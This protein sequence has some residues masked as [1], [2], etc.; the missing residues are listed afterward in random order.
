MYAVVETGGKQYRVQVGEVVDV[1]RLDAGIGDRVELDRVLMV[2][3]DAGTQVGNPMIEGAKVSATVVEQGRG[4]CC[5]RSS[6]NVN[7]TKVL[8]L[9][10]F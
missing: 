6:A 5:I 8:F 10:I 7:G 2:S 3:S 1:E 9:R 4:A